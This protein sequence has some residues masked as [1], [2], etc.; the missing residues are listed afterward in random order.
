MTLRS[1]T[2]AVVAVALLGCSALIVS[3]C[4]DSDTETNATPA[5]TYYGDSVSMGNGAVRS[6]VTLDDS[7]NPTDIGLAI[8]TEALNGLPD[9][10]A[11]PGDPAGSFEVPLPSQALATAFNH[12]EIDWNP[13]GHEP[14]GIYDKPHFDFHFY[15]IDT[16][17]QN[18]ITAVG[19]DTVKINKMPPAD[20][21]PT[22][23]QMIPGGVPRMGAHWY[24]TTAVEFH[25]QPFTSTFIYGFYD[26]RMI[27]DEPMVTVA[28]LMSHPDHSE[29][30]KLPAVY[31]TSAYYPTTYSV[32]YDATAGTYKVSLGGLMMR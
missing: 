2:L 9:T 27:F 3:G 23:Y 14:V 6:Y 5:G 32:T 12:I 8:G 4:S 20:Q 26:G 31:P 18:A 15:M 10:L 24:D 29:Q 1:G 19:A 17:T 7:G 13:H 11:F 22:D 16:A 28:Y 25:G 30:L 21:I